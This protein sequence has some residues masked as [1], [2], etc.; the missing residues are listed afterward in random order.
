MLNNVKATTFDKESQIWQ[1]N[2]YFKFWMLSI[3]WYLQKRFFC[4]TED[5]ILILFKIVDWG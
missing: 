1:D 5:Y 2:G 3:I 4:G